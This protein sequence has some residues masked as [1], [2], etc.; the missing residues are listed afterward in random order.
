MKGEMDLYQLIEAL[1]PVVKDVIGGML[2]MSDSGVV[3]GMREAGAIATYLKESALTFG[4]NP[5]IEGLVEGLLGDDQNLQLPDINSIDVTN[6]FNSVGS[7]ATALSSIEGGDQVKQ[8][9][10]GLA[11]QIA[12]ASGGGLFGSGNKISAGEQQFL[13]GLRAMLGV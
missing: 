8:F 5:I 12:G 2:M 11:V 13:D 6:L 4:G 3:G 10:Y 1:I 7:A 9:I